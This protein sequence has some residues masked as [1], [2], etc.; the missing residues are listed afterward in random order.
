MQRDNCHDQIS[1]GMFGQSSAKRL[2]VAGKELRHKAM[3][4]S[5][6]LCW[7]V[8]HRLNFDSLQGLHNS[9]MNMTLIA[10]KA[11][12]GLLELSAPRIR[13]ARERVAE[14]EVGLA[15]TRI[16]TLRRLGR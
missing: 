16:S 11:L 2:A 9:T 12:V 10:D 6:R 4:A 5:S 1:I 7:D 3:P 15:K 14:I 13:D 8:C